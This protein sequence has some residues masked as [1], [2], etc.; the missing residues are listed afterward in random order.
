MS[1]SH[2]SSPDSYGSDL[3]SPWSSVSRLIRSSE[4][5][6]QRFSTLR[7]SASPLVW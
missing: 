7:S 6:V 2:Y 3:S 1:N 5:H 4:R